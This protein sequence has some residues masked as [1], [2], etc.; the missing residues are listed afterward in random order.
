MRFSQ[1]RRISVR[2]RYNSIASFGWRWYDDHRLEVTNIFLRNTT[3]KASITD[4]FTSSFTLSDGQGFRNYRTRFEERNLM[5][6]QIRGSHR[7]GGITRD[8]LNYFKFQWLDE[9]TLDWFYSDSTSR[10]DIP[11][12]TNVVFKTSVDGAAPIASEN[13]TSLLC[14]G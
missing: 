4:S 3:D 1:I 14:G 8:L 11:N 9:L 6:N 7:F 13:P 12:E 10:T 5:V 2:C